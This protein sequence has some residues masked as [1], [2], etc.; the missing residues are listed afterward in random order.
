[1]QLLKITKPKIVIF[2]GKQV[3]NAIIE[4]CYEIKNSWNKELEYGYYFSE[5]DNIHFI[6]YK[7]LFS[8]IISKENIAE[9]IKEIV[10]M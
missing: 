9:K 6:G 3:Y 2:E 4:E 5:T 10:A 8:N 7:R 1:M